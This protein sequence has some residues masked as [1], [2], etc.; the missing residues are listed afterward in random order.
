MVALSV[1]L[2]RG[3]S[4]ARSNPPT[5]MVIDRALAQDTRRPDC[6]F[7]R[8]PGSPARR[9]TTAPSLFAGQRQFW[10]HISFTA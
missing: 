6:T 5:E 8:M 2:G 3:R 4:Q 1:V 7:L 9:K 10:R